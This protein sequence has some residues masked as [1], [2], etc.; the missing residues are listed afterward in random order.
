MIKER[1]ESLIR[2]LEELNRKGMS[3]TDMASIANVSK[4]AVTG[5]F[6]TGAISKKSAIAIADAAG[7]S[8]AWL[9]GENVDEESGLSDRKRKLLEL[10]NQLPEDDQEKFL[11]MMKVRLEEIDNFIAQYQKTRLTDS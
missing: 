8:V 6:K 7:V 5:W 3:K 11:T 1:N 9:L 10:F 2:R 4:Q